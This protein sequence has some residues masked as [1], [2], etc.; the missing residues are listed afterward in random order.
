LT[1][2]IFG[3]P[4]DH[5]RTASTEY[6]PKGQCRERYSSPFPNGS[7]GSQLTLQRA[8]LRREQQADSHHRYPAVYCPSNLPG[9]ETARKD[10]D[11]LQK[12]DAAKN[13]QEYAADSQ[14]DPHVHSLRGTKQSADLDTIDTMNITNGTLSAD[15]EYT[16]HED[17][18]WSFKL[19]FED[20]PVPIESME[21][22]QTKELAEEQVNYEFQSA[23][24]R[25]AEG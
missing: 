5:F 7:L 14:D 21:N 1:N 16:N 9:H 19:T 12:P 25:I 20:D 4:T 18:T 17:G 2:D 3:D 15:V 6:Y 22:F 8:F 11:P 13:H 23:S 24:L 10:V